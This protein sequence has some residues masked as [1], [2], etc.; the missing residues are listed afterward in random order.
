MGFN[1]TVNMFETLEFLNVRHEE[2]VSR[3]TL[4]NLA[5][6]DLKQ[7]P[8]K[9]KSTKQKQAQVKA[10]VVPYEQVPFS[11]CDVYGMFKDLQQFVE[12]RCQL[13]LKLSSHR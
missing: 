9:S 6:P 8:E 13:L 12:V 5:V 4:E 1:S 10:R 7:S 11:P 2:F 3:R